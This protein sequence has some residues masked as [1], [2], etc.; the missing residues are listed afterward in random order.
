MTYNLPG[1]S[2]VRKQVIDGTLRQV[3]A[4]KFVFRQ[5]CA[6]VSTGAWKNTFWREDPTTLTGVGTTGITR[7]SFKEIGRGAAFPQASASWEE[8]STRILKFG[9]EDVLTW[10][11]VLSDNIDIELR[12]ITKIAEGVASAEDTYIFNGLTESLTPTT[13]QTVTI[14]ATLQ[15]TGASAAII[16]DLMQGK[17]KLKDYNYPT[18]NVIVFI[19]QRQERAIV[20]WVTDKGAQFSS[21]SS[22]V[23][24]N[25]QVPGLAGL[26]FVVSPNVT[27][28][29]ALM[30]VP[31]TCATLKE[32]EPLKTI[33]KDDEGKSRTI[34]AWEQVTLQL[35]E[36][37]AIVLFT[38]TE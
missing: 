32:L 36:P 7:N 21:V 37:K 38:N 13:I 34:R 11:D 31:K 14:G 10:E 20:K 17:Q 12:T 6:V 27:T 9:A 8:V 16:D 3:L 15:W 26:N 35:T 2:S 28:S 4:K 29:C 19:N 30:V 24:L 25:G 22:S 1:S 5:A 18:D 33:T 23:S